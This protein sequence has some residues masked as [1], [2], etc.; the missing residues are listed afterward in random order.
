MD[1]S[2]RL[3]L[4]LEVVEQ[5][6][7]SR[8]ADLRN[9]DR[10][11][12]SKQIAR[13]EQELGVRLLNRT[14]RSLALTA[15]GSE[16]VSQAHQ[17]RAL[18]NNTQRVAQNYHTELAGK[19]RIA[20]TTDFG[21]QYVQQAVL[22][23][24]Q[25]HPQVE[26]ELRLE[27]RIVDLVGEGFDLGFRLGK[28]RDSSLITRRL[29]RNRLL[30]VPS[31]D[32]IERFG[33]ID[34]IAKLEAAPAAVYSAP[35]NLLDKFSYLDNREQTQYFHLNAVY[36]VNDARMIVQAAVA[37]NLLAVV[38]AQMLGR[39]VLEGRLVPVMTHLPLEELGTFY[40]V[41]PHRD[42]PMKTKTFI[43]LLRSIVGEEVP[44]WEQNIPGFSQMYC[45]LKVQ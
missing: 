32:F 15:A 22:A 30:I 8:V 4:L 7:F 43:D 11:V 39:E 42:A 20:S 37:G 16:V 44:V 26:I 2:N 14:T 6:S 29:A 1:F 41:Y 10:S 35:G 18:L 36:R 40:A 13:L 23:F 9:L 31:P 33:A 38:T 17:L 34:T 25:A 19:L 5:G 12:V 3:L 45:P 27:D 24:Q 21:R 28:P